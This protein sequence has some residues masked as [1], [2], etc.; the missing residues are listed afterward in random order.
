VPLKSVS[1]DLTT[2]SLNCYY[3]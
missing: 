1:A 2:I 3:Y